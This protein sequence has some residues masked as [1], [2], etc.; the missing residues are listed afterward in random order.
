M[1]DQSIA[2]DVAAPSLV[3][4]ANKEPPHWAGE[5]IKAWDG[6]EFHRLEPF[7]TATYWCDQGSINVHRVVGT[8]DPDYQGKS[9]LA[10]LNGGKHMDSNL[11]LHRS[12]PGYYQDAGR[13]K[14]SMH[15]VTLDG[16]H[17]YVSIDG[18]HRTCI[19][20]FD[21]HYSG[22]VMLHG[23]TI[24]QHQV[25]RAFYQYYLG[26]VGYAHAHELPIHFTPQQ[27]ALARE[28]TGGWKLDHYQTRLK[29]DNYL[30]GTS[31]ILDREQ[32]LTYLVRLRAQIDKRSRF[33][34]WPWSG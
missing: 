24:V 15:F 20:K 8:Q 32:A 6:A 33:R 12:N 34:L 10:F 11:L 2:I 14:P 9:W 31:E 29:V 16:L 4:R 7:I 23:V 22:R 18:N 26:L 21:F 25:D 30:E 27:S 17:Y 19:A 5:K 13:K 1:V 28:D 3:D